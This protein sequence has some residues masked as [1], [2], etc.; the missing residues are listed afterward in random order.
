MHTITIYKNVQEENS[1]V[2]TRQTLRIVKPSPN[3]IGFGKFGYPNDHEI[4]KLCEDLEP[5][6]TGYLLS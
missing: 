5:T 3:F 4:K 1:R 6:H 2:I